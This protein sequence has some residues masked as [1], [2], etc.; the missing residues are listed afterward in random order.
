MGASFIKHGI[1]AEAPMGH[2]RSADTA[3]EGNDS[4]SGGDVAAAL[5]ASDGHGTLVGAG[6]PPGNGTVAYTYASGELYALDI[7]GDIRFGASGWVDWNAILDYHGGPNHVNRSDI[8]APILV[9][10]ASNSYYVQSPYYY[11]GHISRF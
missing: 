4:V 11:M 7:L 5:G 9:D 10:I 1:A 6:V 3:G 2:P 8:G